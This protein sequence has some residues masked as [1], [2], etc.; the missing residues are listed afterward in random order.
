VPTYHARERIESE[1]LAFTRGKNR[2]V[3]QDDIDEIPASEGR[4]PHLLARGTIQRE[5]RS[6]ASDEYQV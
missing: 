2:V 5:D 4:H 6:F 3:L 1:N